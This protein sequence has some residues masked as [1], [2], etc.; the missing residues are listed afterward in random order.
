MDDSPPVP[1]SFTYVAWELGS[2]RIGPFVA[3][4][5]R[6]NEAVEVLLTVAAEVGQ[7]SGTARVRVLA[8]TFIPPLKG[9]P[10]FDLVFLAHG[11]RAL[12]DEVLDRARSAGLP[13][14]ALA[15]M[16]TNVVR[17]GDTDERDGNV[18]LN[19][20]V[21]NASATDAVAAWTAAS[22]WY[23]DALG[24][25]NSTLLQ[26]EQPC[27]FLVTNYARIPGAV[28]PFMMQ[29]LLRPSFYREVWRVLKQTG[30]RPFPVF[31]REVHQ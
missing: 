29:Q 8:A 3:R 27:P 11:E 12:R 6:R 14:P 15:A 1:G 2:P 20:F 7:L 17:F 13:E 19:H 25:D 4:N 16:A 26:F 21:G 23:S 30:V 9:G 28:A 18:L 24:V 22:H 10:R 5:R 31:L